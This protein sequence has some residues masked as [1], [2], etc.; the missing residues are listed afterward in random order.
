MTDSLKT[1]LPSNIFDD[2]DNE[3]VFDSVAKS[4]DT[5]LVSQSP[6]TEAEMFPQTASMKASVFNLVNS[7][8]GGGVLALPFGFKQVGVFLGLILLCSIGTLSAYSA[9]LLVRCRQMTLKLGVERKP[10][11][12]NIV[13]VTFGTRGAKLVELFIVLLMLGACVGYIAIIGET[14]SNSFSGA[15]G[16]E[17]WYTHAW[18]IQLSLLSFVLFPLSML[19][20]VGALKYTSI[21]ALCGILFLVV[22]IIVKF[23][24]NFEEALQDEDDKFIDYFNWG[25]NMFASIPI[26]TFAFSMHMQM[27]PVWQELK[28]PTPKRITNIVLAAIVIC[29][30]LY[31][32][33]ITMPLFCIFFLFSIGQL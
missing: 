31:A 19:S 32:D 12:Y 24:S 29:G 7:I 22:C 13:C 2:V 23:A 11:Y 26:M 33:L 21:I 8:V 14:L 6:T 9:Y 15:L 1:P 25:T 18:V 10:S 4:E 27:F 17:P 30:V 20:T 5:P 28:Q 16:Y 3:Q